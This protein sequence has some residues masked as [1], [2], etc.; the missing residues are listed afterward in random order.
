MCP[1]EGYH[2]RAFL[3]W[4]GYRFCP[5]SLTLGVYSD[6]SR[7]TFLA[8]TC[9]RGHCIAKKKRKRLAGFSYLIYT[10]LGDFPVTQCV[11]VTT[12]WG[13][14]KVPPQYGKPDDV[15]SIA[16]HGQSPCFAA[17]PPTIL[18][19]GLTPH[20]P[21]THR[22]SGACLTYELMVRLPY[23]GRNLTAKLYKVVDCTEPLLP[24]IR[25][26]SE[27]GLRHMNWIGL[28]KHIN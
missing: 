3:V 15:R 12:H 8:L 10:E 4:K 24:E 27:L 11:A 25:S 6:V 2:F 19:F 14:T 23:L 5:F 9:C 16:C 21:A 13:A 20:E 22:A 7:I 26:Q 28:F 17:V 18:V 1:P